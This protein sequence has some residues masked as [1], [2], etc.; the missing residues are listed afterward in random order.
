VSAIF[1]QALSAVNVGLDSFAEP[2]EQAGV[3]VQTL[4]WRPPAAGDAEL[5]LVLARWFDDPEV[6]AAN[7]TALDR[8]L[9]ARPMLTDLVTA[10]EAI[11]ELRT[12]RLLLH[13]GPPVTWERMCGPMRGAVVGAILL[14]GWART[15]ESAEEKAASGEIK[16]SPAHHFDAVG[17]MA[18]VISP[19]MPVYVVE[20]A[21]GGIRAFSTINEG[22]GK[23]LRFGAYDEAVLRR[24][25]WMTSV[26]APTLRSAIH[27]LPEPVDLKKT[28]AQALLMGDECHNRNVASTALFIRTLAP[29]LARMGGDE[30]AEALGFMRD[31]AHFFLN[32]S[33]AACKVMLLAGHDIPRSTL[34]TTMARN[35]VEFGIR[36]S[37]CRDRW[38]VAPAPVPDGLYFPGYGPE[39]ANPDL[40]DSAITETAGIGAFAM[41]AAPAI[42]GFIGGTAHGAIDHTRS[43]ATITLGQNSEYQISA[44][45]FT[46]SPVGIDVRAV[47]DTNT[48]PVINTGIAHRRPG[49]GQVGA[50]LTR[51]PLDCFRAALAHLEG[52]R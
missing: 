9:A 49:I 28:T 2:L 39:D 26:L 35:G 10:S 23:A 36:V 18:G 40:G 42:V 32:L 30:A 33:M 11:P 34:V 7:R 31:N 44:L 21:G 17:P 15:P 24:L 41:A 51:A 8:V 19:S 48:Q 47:L 16:F 37:G 22:L 52:S 12:E 46:G 13:A 27:S 38:F 5:G 50:G 6:E 14:E 20:D 25:E 29:V 4:D 43:M 45:G 1:G 3:P